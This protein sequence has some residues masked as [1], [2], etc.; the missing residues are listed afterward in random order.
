MNDQHHEAPVTERER[1]ES[2]AILEDLP[3]EAYSLACDKD[4][5]CADQ[6]GI[7]TS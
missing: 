6:G 5:G 7:A 4:A 2:P 1:Y 3:L